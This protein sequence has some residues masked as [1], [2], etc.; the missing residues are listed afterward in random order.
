[1]RGVSILLKKVLDFRVMVTQKY[2]NSR[3]LFLKGVLMLAKIYTPNKGQIAFLSKVLA[4]LI[5][6][7][8][9]RSLI[10]G[11]FNMITDF[12]KDRADHHSRKPGNPT[13]EFTQL[14]SLLSN[15]NFIDIWHT[16][17]PFERDYTFYSR[18]HD[19]HTRTD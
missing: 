8:E 3:F 7:A 19:V 1:M 6:F 4:D 9:G 12:T 11:D 16:K 15:Y 13:L 17:H 2:R 5:K 18:R 10:A 14:K